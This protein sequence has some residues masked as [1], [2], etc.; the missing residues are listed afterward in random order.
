MARIRGEAIDFVRDVSGDAT[1]N[2][3]NYVFPTFIL[4]YL[5]IGLVGLLIAA[6]F[7]AAMSTISSEL[8][9]LSTAT[10]IDF[11]R[12]FARPEAGDAH[13]LRVSRVSTGLWGV[14]ASIVAV[15]A[16]E[17][18]SLIEVVNRF[19]SFF[20]GSILGVFVLGVGLPGTTANGAFIGLLAG[21]ASVAWVASATDIAFLWHN[22]VGAVVVVVVGLIVSLADPARRAGSASQ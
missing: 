10:V 15:Y 4:T 1:Y 7:A 22:V 14:F 16:A 3:V 21:M 2:D 17:L 9:A 11:Y 19:G 20:Y 12:R 18:G 13:L 5:P 6:I 8:A